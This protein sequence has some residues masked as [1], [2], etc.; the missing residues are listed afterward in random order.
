MDN[1]IRNNI[2]RFK[3][4]AEGF[5]KDNIKAFI[6]DINNSYH[7]CNITQVNSNDLYIL[8]FAGKKINEEEKLF[9]ADIIK[10]EEYKTR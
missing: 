6:V 2:E 3:I 8:N 10:F 5:L 1:D 7:F 4:K 9:W